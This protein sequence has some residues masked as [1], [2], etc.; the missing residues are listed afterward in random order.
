[1]TNDPSRYCGECGTD[2]VGN[3]PHAPA[4]PAGPDPVEPGESHDG[5]GAHYGSASRSYPP[6]RVMVAR[7]DVTDLTDAEVDALVGEVS[8]QAEQS[9]R[10]DADGGHAGVPAPEIAFEG[11]FDEYD[12]RAL[13]R[14][15]A[16][17]AEAAELYVEG[18]L[19]VGAD[20]DAVPGCEL[21]TADVEWVDA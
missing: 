8:V 14:V 18:A 2:L 9:D 21:V 12:V 15:R 10:D 4:C 17:S 16:P 19:A 5:E 3:D 6:R 1:M 7:F 13:V 11:G 20:P